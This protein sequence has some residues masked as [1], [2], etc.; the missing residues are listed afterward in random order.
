VVV[1]S[2]LAY[3][4]IGARARPG[5]IRRRSKAKMDKELVRYLIAKRRLTPTCPKC[6]QI[7]TDPRHCHPHN[8]IGAVEGLLA[9][10]PCLACNKQH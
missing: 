5:A 7:V 9:K 10:V 4:T 3:A 2:G 8:Y 6:K 1:D